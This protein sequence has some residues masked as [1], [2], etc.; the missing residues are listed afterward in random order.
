MNCFSTNRETAM[1]R[2][3]VLYRVTGLLACLASLHGCAAATVVRKQPDFDN[4]RQQ[5][6]MQ[7]FR[8]ETVALG[9]AEAF[10]R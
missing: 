3:N 1:A 10:S 6:L 5:H 7:T 8:Q 9:T 4:E 2:I